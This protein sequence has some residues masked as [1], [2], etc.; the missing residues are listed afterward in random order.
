MA[1]AVTNVRNED[2]KNSWSQLSGMD[3]KSYAELA[4]KARTTLQDKVKAWRVMFVTDIRHEDA[5]N[6]WS[7][8]SAIH[9]APEWLWPAGG[10]IRMGGIVSKCAL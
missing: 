7:Q 1:L 5:K 9:S 4:G 3:L 2:A 10:L 8:L 6:S